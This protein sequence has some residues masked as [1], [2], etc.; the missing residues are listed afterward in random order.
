[1]LVLL[2]NFGKVKGRALIWKNVNIS[3]LDPNLDVWININSDLMDRVYVINSKDRAKFKSYADKNKMAFRT[4]FRAG[5]NT[6]FTINGM[7]VSCV[8][9]TNELLIN[10]DYPH[11]DT[12]CYSKWISRD[13]I[14]LGNA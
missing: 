14:S 12:L 9:K 6:N 4:D 3:Y 13:K 1:M 8:I 11:L 10:N 5:S 2:D 7:R